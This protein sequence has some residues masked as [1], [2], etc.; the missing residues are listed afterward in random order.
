MGLLL[1]ERGTLERFMTSFLT[2]VSWIY[3]NPDEVTHLKCG[4]NGIVLKDIFVSQMFKLNPSI[5]SAALA[6][7]LINSINVVPPTLTS[8]VDIIKYVTGFTTIPVDDKWDGLVLKVFEPESP[9]Q[10][11]FHFTNSSTFYSNGQRISS[12]T[13]LFINGMPV[14]VDFT[15]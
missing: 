10:N 11:T 1:I 4:E 9:L 14:V 15:T 13:V 6:S 12:H 5:M 7:A 8:S 2:D 3:L